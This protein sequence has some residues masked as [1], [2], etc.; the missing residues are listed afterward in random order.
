MGF[1]TS[2]VKLAAGGLVL[3]KVC[4]E[5]NGQYKYDDPTNTTTPAPPAPGG[6]P[7]IGKYFIAAA[8]GIVGF[9]GSLCWLLCS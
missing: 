9:L 3:F 6:S 5:V 4:C 8:I 1:L 2:R 7:D